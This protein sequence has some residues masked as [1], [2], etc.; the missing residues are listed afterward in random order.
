MCHLPIGMLTYSKLDGGSKYGLFSPLLVE[1]IQ[2]DGPHI[3]QAG[4]FNHQLGKLPM[5][6]WISSSSSQLVDGTTLLY[7]HQIF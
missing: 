5:Q 3:F 1:M 6:K 2:F 7:W 4:W